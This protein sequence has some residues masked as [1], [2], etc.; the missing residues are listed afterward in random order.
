MMLCFNFEFRVSKARFDLLSRFDFVPD[1]VQLLRTALLYP[2][3]ALRDFLL[4]GLETP[5]ELLIGAPQ[6]AFGIGVE[7][8]RQIGRR[9]QQIA[10]FLFDAGRGGWR[11]P[12]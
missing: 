4:E 6:A 8:A 10:D 11:A 9:E 5:L 1:A 12:A 7:E 2:L 3:P